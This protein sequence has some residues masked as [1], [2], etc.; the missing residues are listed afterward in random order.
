MTDKSITVPSEFGAG[1]TYE[2]KNTGA[3]PHDF[4]LAQLAGKPLPDLFQC[5]EGSF[6]NGQPIDKC[7]GTLAGGVNTLQPGE[8]AF[9]TITLPPGEYGYLS[10]EG[11]GADVQAGLVGT[12]TVK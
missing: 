9:L 12:F 5:V 2:V 3:K 7:P 10:T 1:G 11:D 4:S 6:G 8:S